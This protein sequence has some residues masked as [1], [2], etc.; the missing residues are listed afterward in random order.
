M[1]KE[2][3]KLVYLPDK[4]ALKPDKS[5]LAVM[6]NPYWCHF[7]FWVL[8]GIW[9]T[10]LLYWLTGQR[11]WRPA[12]C[13]NHSTVLTAGPFPPIHSSWCP[14]FIHLFIISFFLPP[15]LSFPFFPPFSPPLLIFSSSFCLLRHHCPS[16]LGLCWINKSLTWWSWSAG[17]LAQCHM[18]QLWCFIKFLKSQNSYW[19]L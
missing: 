14:L 5:S 18:V 9:L 8:S 11:T 6:C 12:R 7:I 4:E 10:A 1:E 17:H 16:R 13:M 15:S 19:Y 3:D 2:F